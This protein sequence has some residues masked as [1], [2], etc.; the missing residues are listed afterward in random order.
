MFQTQKAFGCLFPFG[1]FETRVVEMV[2]KPVHE[3]SYK[4]LSKTGSPDESVLRR[5]FYNLQ[6]PG[7]GGRA[8]AVRAPPRMAT[9]QAMSHRV[10]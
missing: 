8:V 7:L 1:L 2:V 3:D 10:V 4:L 5:F 9:R 6:S